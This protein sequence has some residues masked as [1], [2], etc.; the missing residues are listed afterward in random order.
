MQRIHLLA[1]LLTFAVCCPILR[2]SEFEDAKNKAEQFLTRYEQIRSLHPKEIR[3]L[4]ATICE[5]DGDEDDFN[6]LSKQ[7]TERLRDEVRE[8]IEDL[9][10]RHEEASAALR[11]AEND[12]ASKDRQSEA[13]SLSERIDQVW[14]RIQNI[15]ADEIRGGN[16]PVVNYLR[17][18][19]QGSHKDYQEHSGK[20]TVDEFQT[21]EGPADCLW[22]EKCYVIELKPNNSRAISKGKGQADKYAK[23]LNDNKDDSFTNLLKKTS[24]FNSCKGHFVP[25]V[26]A[27]MACP[28]IDDEGRVRES[29]FGW[30]DPE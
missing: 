20:C 22:A 21:G 4:V 30:S 10:K 26:A 29:S 14:S 8:N 16:N 5:N 12:P 15:S 11:R 9:N 19:G 28:E 3:A 27:Y 13:R 7:A 1:G 23:A 25:K 18:M 6:A 24:D 17:K 2:A